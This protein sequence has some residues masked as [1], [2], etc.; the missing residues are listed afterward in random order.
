MIWGFPKIGVPQN[1]WFIWKTR[2]KWMI[3]GYHHLRKHPHE[4]HV[5]NLVGGFEQNPFE[6]YDMLVKMGE[7]LP[8]FL[9]KKS[10]KYLSCHYLATWD[11]FDKEVLSKTALNS[12]EQ[13]IKCFQNVAF[14]PRLKTAPIRSYKTKE[15]INEHHLVMLSKW[16]EFLFES[17][18]NLRSRDTRFQK[19]TA[20]VFSE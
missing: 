6:K 13:N 8:N 12:L 18:K 19:S 1:G 10:K 9:D 5:T 2:L 3:W 15:Q 17:E 20:M 11:G 4:L 16:E 7:N 14:F